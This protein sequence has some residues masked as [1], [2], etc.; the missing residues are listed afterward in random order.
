MTHFAISYPNV[1]SPRSRNGSLW[2]VFVTPH[3]CWP[4]CC[5]CYTCTGPTP[6]TFVA[7]WSS[8][9][10]LSDKE[11]RATEQSV[12]LLPPHPVTPAHAA[13]C[14]PRRA[15]RLATAPPSDPPFPP[16]RAPAAK[17]KPTAHPSIFPLPSFGWSD[18]KVPPLFQSPHVSTIHVAWCPPHLG[19]LFACYGPDL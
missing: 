13:A 19:M 16:T 8:H 18:L 3:W 2:S 1:G 4:I 7:P 12:S 15:Y 5:D 9:L 17:F 6:R 14:S 10:Q 11:E